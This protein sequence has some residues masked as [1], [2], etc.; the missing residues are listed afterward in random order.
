VIPAV[1]ETSKN[2]GEIE[3]RRYLTT[4]ARNQFAPLLK[5]T[6]LP[7]ELLLHGGNVAHAL[8]ET[9]KQESADLLVIG[10]GHLQKRLGRLRT[11]S[12][13]IVCESPCPVVSF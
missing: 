11:Q 6:D 5:E 13:S 9:A 1:D 10:R 12:L 8:A 3:L 2:R 7:L 4:R